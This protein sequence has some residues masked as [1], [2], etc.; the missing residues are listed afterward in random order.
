MK[1]PLMN[2]RPIVNVSEMLPSDNPSFRKQGSTRSPQ[3]RKPVLG[4]LH[5]NQQKSFEEYTALA[6]AAMG[7]GDRVLAETYY[8]YA[9]YAVRLINQAK[10]DS[11]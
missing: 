3:P 2:N 11:D 9:E 6:Q 8:Q 5:N 10:E 1:Y 4:K 7:Q